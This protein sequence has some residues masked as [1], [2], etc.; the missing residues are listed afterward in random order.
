M[1]KK[2]ILCVLL[3]FLSTGCSKSEEKELTCEERMKEQSK[4]PEKYCKDGEYVQSAI[5][6]EVITSEVDG[7]T[8][9]ETKYSNTIMKESDNLQKYYTTSCRVIVDAE[10]YGA[11]F[12]RSAL[13]SQNTLAS[14]SD[15]Q[16]EIYGAT[17]DYYNADSKKYF[18]YGIVLRHDSIEITSRNILNYVSSI[19][20]YS[21]LD[22]THV[23][24]IYMNPDGISG[25]SGYV[26]DNYFLM[27]QYSTFITLFKREYKSSD[28]NNMSLD[29]VDTK[30]Y[31]NNHL[32]DFYFMEN[33]IKIVTPN[34]TIEGEFM[35]NS[36]DG[37]LIIQNEND[38]Y[39]FEET[40]L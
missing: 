8:I 25:A 24:A 29:F 3:V 34:L 16:A 21:G 6:P 17:Y 28:G 12:K 2:I 13:I 20:R 27:G 15:K 26:E 37:T 36:N 30:V 31:L 38:T 18:D 19:L 40:W 35:Q 14:I 7:I 11:N 4:N 39:E 22:L 23:K 1:M 10:L 9:Y 32:A 5:P 33:Y